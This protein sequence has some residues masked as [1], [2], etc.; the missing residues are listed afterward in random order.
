MTPEY[1]GRILEAVSR[2]QRFGLRSPIDSFPEGY[3]GSHLSENFC[4]RINHHI[5]TNFFP[6]GGHFPRGKCLEIANLVTENLWTSFDTPCMYVLGWVTVNGTAKWFFDDS[7]LSG[8]MTNGIPDLN[9][10]KMHA[11]CML[12]SGEVIDPTLNANLS[13]GTRSGTVFWRAGATDCI[14]YYPMILG[15]QALTKL[16]LGFRP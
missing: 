12:D 13:A 7:D 14:D 2:T 11:W 15:A 8:W 9:N 16:G 5:V 4:T 3:I 10:V 6:G 1:R